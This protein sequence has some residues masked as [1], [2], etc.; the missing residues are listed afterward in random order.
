MNQTIKFNVYDAL[1]VEWNATKAKKVFLGND[2]LCR[3]KQKKLFIGFV[4]KQNYTKR[5]IVT[6]TFLL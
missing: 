6:F 5:K 3:D 1:S 4:L 2:Q